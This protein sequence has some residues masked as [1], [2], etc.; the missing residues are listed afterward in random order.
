MRE[1][2]KNKSAFFPYGLWKQRKISEPIYKS[3]TLSLFLLIVLVY[4]DPEDLKESLL[5]LCN[6][7]HQLYRRQM[8]K[9]YRTRPTHLSPLTK[10]HVWWYS[11][12]IVSVV[13]WS[14]PFIAHRETCLQNLNF[15]IASF[16]DGRKKI[17]L[18]LKEKLDMSQWGLCGAAELFPGQTATLGQTGTLI[19]SCKSG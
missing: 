11:V 19:I 4:R 1:Y 18:S 7:G 14:K 9:M 5:M 10:W 2:L 16:E 17:L 15:K 13:V 3:S 12:N 8:L 6:N